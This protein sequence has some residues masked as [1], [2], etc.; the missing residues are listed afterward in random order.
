MVSK[1]IDTRCKPGY[2]GIKTFPEVNLFLPRLQIDHYD[3]QTSTVFI[4][5]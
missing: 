3:E 2:D 4:I 5:H 1:K